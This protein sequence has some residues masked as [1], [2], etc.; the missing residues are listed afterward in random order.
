MTSVVTGRQYQ[1]GASYRATVTDPARDSVLF[2]EWPVIAS[3]ISASWAP[4]AP[5]GYAMPAG[6]NGPVR[7]LDGPPAGW[8]INPNLM[9]RRAGVA[10]R[11]AG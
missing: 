7:A 11:E 9:P 5:D 2:R 4:L 6:L 1:V 10:G 3:S 8:R